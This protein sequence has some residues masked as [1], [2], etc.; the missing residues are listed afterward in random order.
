M[1]HQIVSAR[2]Y[3]IWKTYPVTIRTCAFIIFMFV[4]MAIG[5]LTVC[6]TFPK[7]PSR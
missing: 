3:S 2:D 7:K 4:A 6:F 5:I 1:I